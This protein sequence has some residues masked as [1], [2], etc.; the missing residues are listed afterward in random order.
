MS[1]ISLVG[2]VG[3]LFPYRDASRIKKRERENV[4]DT[5]N[6]RPSHRKFTGSYGD[7]WMSS[8]LDLDITCLMLPILKWEEYMT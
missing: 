3:G 4:L 6:R 7:S 8:I 5:F 2:K 1:L